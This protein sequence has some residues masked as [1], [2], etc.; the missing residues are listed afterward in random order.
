MLQ[1]ERFASRFGQLAMSD[2]DE[3]NVC[4]WRIENAQ[5]KFKRAGLSDMLQSGVYRLKT[6][7]TGVEHLFVLKICFEQ[8]NSNINFFLADGPRQNFKVDGVIWL[9]GG[10]VNSK[11]PKGEHIFLNVVETKTVA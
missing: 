2:D 10:N 6:L 1:S 11:T 4:R 7:K 5:D 9:E 8:T 3:S